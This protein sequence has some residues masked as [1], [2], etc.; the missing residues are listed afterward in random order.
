MYTVQIFLNCFDSDASKGSEE[1]Q[2]MILMP[3]RSISDDMQKQIRIY[4]I[5]KCTRNEMRQRRGNATTLI[6]QV[7]IKLCYQ[8][9][10]F[11]AFE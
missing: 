4:L 6:I 7:E 8:A 3:Q 10:M 11:I 5:S 1:F 9:P 2:A